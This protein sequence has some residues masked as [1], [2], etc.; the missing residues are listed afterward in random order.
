MLRPLAVI[1]DGEDDN[2][3]QFIAPENFQDL[4]FGEA[5]IVES[6]FEDLCVTG[7]DQGSRNTRWAA[8]GEGDSLSERQLRKARDDVLLG[9][10]FEFSRSGR[11][12]RKLDEVHE[13]EVAQKA[14]AD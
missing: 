11:R 1:G 4:G 3:G 7:S 2:L 9:V 13:V 6:Y 8:A 12:Q 5:G 14:K 10:E